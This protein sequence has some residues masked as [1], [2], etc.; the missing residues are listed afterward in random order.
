MKALLKT[1]F[2]RLSKDKLLL[3]MGIVAVVF[4]A[5]TPLLYAALFSG[6]GMEDDPMLSAFITGKAQFFGSFSL[7]NNLGLIA[8]VLLAIALC[9]D[10]SYGTVRNK[11]IAGKSR[12]AIFLSLFVTCATVLITVMLLHAFL[13]LG[14]SLMFFEYQPTPFTMAD[15]GYFL[16]SLAFEIL[17]LLWVAAL[18]SC[19]C[20]CMKNVGLVIVLYIAISFALVIAGSI[21]QVVLMVME[22]MVDHE[23]MV[24]V[25]RFIDRINVANAAT[26][27]GTGTT[28]TLEDVLYLT[29]PAT[30]GTLGLLGLGLWRF[31]KKDLK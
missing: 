15:F 30:A 22:T 20:A 11:I 26:Y 28:Y 24:Q 2:K 29:L 9:K 14:I 21:L 19:L 16:A 4:A 6:M 8:P 1:D 12:S 3:V 23:S 7:G 5:M 17:V 25:L 27:I 31:N 13:T 18:L 10:F